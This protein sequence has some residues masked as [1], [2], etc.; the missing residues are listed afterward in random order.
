M[1]SRLVGPT[2]GL[3]LSTLSSP[4]TCPHGSRDR[5]GLQ[6][7]IH[8]TLSSLCLLTTFVRVHRFP[9]EPAIAKTGRFYLKA[10]QEERFFTS[11]R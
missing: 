8:F 10:R 9:M 5:V 2:W 3:K 1:L 7:R 11:L 6:V 4:P